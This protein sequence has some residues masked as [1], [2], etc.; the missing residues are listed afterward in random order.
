MQN[1]QQKE[2]YMTE[3]IFSKVNNSLN[4]ILLD[5]M[6]LNISLLKVDPVSYDV[7]V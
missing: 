2:Q 4:V 5:H 6:I 1:Y 3:L 7:I